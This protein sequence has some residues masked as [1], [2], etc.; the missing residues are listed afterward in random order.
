MLP[1]IEQQH[2]HFG[3]IKICRTSSASARYFSPGGNS[4]WVP[5][6]VNMMILLHPKPHFILV[7]TCNHYM[8][9]CDVFC[10]NCA[11]WVNNAMCFSSVLLCF[12]H[13]SS[14]YFVWESSGSHLLSILCLNPCLRNSE[15]SL[16]F[17]VLFWFFYPLW[18]IATL[19]ETQL[20][21]VFGIF[22]WIDLQ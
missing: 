17:S 21:H 15:K 11:A 13:C 5:N 22:M 18:F 20:A 3:N 19:C 8:L 4:I 7:Q 1:N 2:N 14:W 6:Y 16:S 10:I 9:A 12:L